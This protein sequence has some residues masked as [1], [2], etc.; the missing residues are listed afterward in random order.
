MYVSGDANL[1]NPVLTKSGTQGNVWK[2]ASVDVG[3]GQT[4]RQYTMSISEVLK[5]KL[6]III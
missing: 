6:R 2:Q 1:G 4:S 3:L 5:R